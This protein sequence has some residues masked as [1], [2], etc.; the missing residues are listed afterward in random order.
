MNKGKIKK[1]VVL[2]ISA[3]ILLAVILILCF[4]CKKKDTDKPEREVHTLTTDNISTGD[5]VTDDTGEKTSTNEAD[6][7]S[8]ENSG[9]SR[10]TVEVGSATATTEIS[11]KTMDAESSTD[12]STRSTTESTTRTSTEKTTRTST[13]Y[14]TRVTT[15]STTESTTERTTEPS[16][17]K[18]TKTT[19]ESTT[20]R[21]TESTTEKTTRVTTEKTT[22]STS[23]STTE[24]T[25]QHTHNYKHAPAYD[26]PATCCE[27]GVKVYLCDCGASKT[28]VIK[29]TGK[30][31]WV[32]KTHTETIHHDAV[33][34]DVPIYDDGWWEDVTVT[35]YHCGGCGQ[36]FDTFEELENHLYENDLHGSWGTQP[37]VVDKIWHEPELLG[38][39]T[40]TD[41]PAY[42]EVVEVKDYE[43]CSYCGKKK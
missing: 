32:W 20:E 3:V 43:Y 28:E 42:D 35:K 25:T 11:T 18:T 34:H 19:T 22:E 40:I 21:T 39:N 17:E 6:S 4:S 30:H 31:N 10:L 36:F 27:D 12:K 16:T 8:S 14:T 1:R 13:E 15:R 37:V 7:S 24:K 41:E 9:T 2:I 26:N 23:E 38:Y 5:T 29:A 33:T